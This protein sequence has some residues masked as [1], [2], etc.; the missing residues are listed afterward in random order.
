MIK[1]VAEV[2][3]NPDPPG[4]SHSEIDELFE[5]AG[6]A[7][8]AAGKSKRNRITAALQQAQH[9]EGSAAP[10]ARFLA[11]AMA[12]ARYLREQARFEA[13]RAELRPALAVAGLDLDEGGRLVA[14]ESVAATL[15]DVA[16]ITDHLRIEL[17]R[18]GVHPKAL[19]YCD[20][21]L[22]RKSLFH[23][24]FEAT[25]GVSDRLR[26]MTGLQLDGKAVVEKALCGTAPLLRI[27]AFRSE[28]DASE[29]SGF[30]NLLTGIFGM[31]RNPP[32]HST[33]I[34]TTWTLTEHDA[35]DLFTTLALIHRRLDNARIVL[36]PE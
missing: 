12:I 31:F 26:E 28:T 15:E 29:Q 13:L 11:E 22:V 25:K 34:H 32:A 9:Q 1:A 16:R 18:R 36:P 24:V 30:A 21:E 4:L 3:G 19:Y 17:L 35:L 7:D 6:L 10:I 33:R 5:Q 2:L 23:A 8:P 14:A 27:N 20:E